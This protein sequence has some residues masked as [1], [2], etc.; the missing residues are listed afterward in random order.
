MTA[1]VRRNADTVTSDIWLLDHSLNYV[2]LAYNAIWADPRQGKKLYGRT[3]RK[4]FNATQ[5]TKS[6]K[7]AASQLR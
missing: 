6:S 7:Y 1:V 5:M 4:R 3:H 2:K